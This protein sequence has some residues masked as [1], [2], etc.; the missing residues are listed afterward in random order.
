MAGGGE[1]TGSSRRAFLGQ[2]AAAGFA[3]LGMGRAQ[4][5]PPP[6]VDSAPEPSRPESGWSAEALDQIAFPLGGIGA[7]MICL[8]GTGSL[9]SFSLRN[10][11]DVFN[12]PCVFAALAI[13]GARPL[14]L[15][16]EGPVP[17]RKVFARPGGGEG[18][19]GCSYGLPR[20]ASAQFSARFPFAE[21]T[22]RDPVMPLTAEL[23]GW[24]PFLPGDADNSSL[25]VAALEYRFTNPT[26]QPVSAVFS[27]NAENFMGRWEGAG[28]ERKLVG[29]TVGS[30]PHGFSFHGAAGSFAA[31]VDDPAVQVNHAWFRG[32]WWDGLSMAWKEI[33]AGASF[34]RPVVASG[35]APA[36]ATLFVPFELA[37][38]LSKTVAVRLAWYCAEDGPRWGTPAPAAYRP[39]YS[40]R[41]RDLAAADQ[42]WNA[43]YAALKSASAQFADCFHRSSLPPAV[44]EAVAANL[45]ILKSPTVLRQTDGRLWL[46]EGSNDAAGSGHGSCTHVWNYAQAFAH[47]FPA[48]ERTLRE[49]EFGPMQNAD[50]CQAFRIDLPIRPM[51]AFVPAADGQLG[52]I[53]K[54]YRDWQISGDTAWLRG[55]WPRI[56]ASLD[57]CIRTWDPSRRGWI[58]T[59]HHN[60]YDIEFYGPTGMVTSLYLG[61]LQAAALMGAALTDDVAG[62]RQLLESGTRRANAELFNGEYFIQKVDREM[63]RVAVGELLPE[64]HAR[65][66]REGP[67][68]QYATGCLSDGV[69]GSWLAHV[70][71]VG[72]ILDRTKVASHVAAVQRYNLKSSLARQANP[73]RPGYA[74]G[75]DGGLLLCTWPHGD[76]PSL[77]FPYCDEVWTGVEYQ[78]AAHLISLGHHQAGL[79]IVKTCRARYTGGTRNP[80]NEYEYGHWYG[81]ALASYSLLQ[82]YSGARYDAV[83][84]TLH[85]HPSIAGDFHCFL[86]TAS[87]YG[88]V[89]VRAGKPFLDV[90]S[91]RIEIGSMDYRPAS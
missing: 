51:T 90:K 80:F 33:S 24:S 22:L 16:L 6:R 70:C 39:W 28:Y 3:A 34:A 13:R 64:D 14:A 69:M 53:M 41:F 57:F 38:G 74:T 37:P 62:Y 77:P 89:G 87:G 21:V 76:K 54:V 85:L 50:G 84:R 81:R 66:E 10:Q 30:I 55:L 2:A 11:P 9:T 68:Y 15:V 48:L 27:F 86:A 35:P 65:F 18:D 75:N 79:E 72:Q 40:G 45:S 32:G 83:T 12:E 8:E 5:A 42:Y 17:R 82:A 73:Q 47:L 25:P 19:V 43:Q 67:K 91:G 78:V 59:P 44:L 71:G 49:T 63:A 58:E 46:W 61:A 56:R 26:T 4:A 31:A 36:G 60:T 1:V 88:T 7:G 20:F 29:A 52:G 23:T